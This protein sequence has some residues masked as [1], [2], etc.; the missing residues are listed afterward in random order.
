MRSLRFLRPALPALALF[1]LACPSVR[2]A[3]QVTLRNGSEFLCAHQEAVGDRI[4]LYLYPTSITEAAQIDASYIDVAAVS[5]LRIETVPDPIL[6][7]TP[8]LGAP[9]LDSE[10]LEGKRPAPLTAAETRQLL[11]HAGQAHNIDADL[12][13]S[14]LHAESNGNPRAVSRAGARGLMQLM[15]ATAAKL[16]VENSFAPE[17]NVN[18]G[19]AYL[20]QLLT[21]YHDNISLALAAYNAGPEAVD[22]YHGI[23][24]YAETRAYVA[25]IIREFNQR[26]YNR[27][28]LAANSN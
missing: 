6:P 24:P 8:S 19:T 27:R 16:G 11:A 10:T 25:R 4:R 14:V 28:K 9:R 15:P 12:L 21:R 2:A 3:Q 13:A 26:E 17:Q 1:A 22:R 23:P 18:G 20:D 5:V 7:A